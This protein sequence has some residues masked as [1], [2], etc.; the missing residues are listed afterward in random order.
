VFQF[1]ASS[2]GTGNDDGLLIETTPGKFANLAG[3]PYRPEDPDFGNQYILTTKDGTVYKINA[4]D[5]K[6][7]SVADTNG[8]RLANSWEETVGIILGT[9]YTIF[10]LR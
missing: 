3:R 10:D 8:N 1:S 9:K 5:G 2:V 4:T 6:L 7:E